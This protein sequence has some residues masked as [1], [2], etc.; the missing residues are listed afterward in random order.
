VEILVN[1]L[2]VLLIY[3]GAG[4]LV[5]ALT[6]SSLA[7]LAPWGVFIAHMAMSGVEAYRYATQAGVLPCLAY[8]LPHGIL[9]I[10]GLML[11]CAVGSR[12]SL[13]RKIFPH[14]ALAI[15]L[16]VLGAWVEVNVTPFPL[17]R[18]I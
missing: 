8:V 9:E 5:K 16:I 7:P 17:T 12:L 14:L 13:G 2:L 10:P 6:G 3:A 18:W 4:L 1:N 15:T 11:A